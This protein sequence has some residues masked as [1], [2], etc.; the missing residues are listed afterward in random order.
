[1][2][3][4]KTPL[5][6]SLRRVRIRAVL[7]LGT[8]SPTPCS[9]KHFWIFKRLN[10]LT[11]CSISQFLIFRKMF[12]NITKNPHADPKFPRDGDVQKQK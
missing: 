1:M 9:V 2:C 6:V 5:S 8:Q 11:P 10:S 12:E 4:G 3:F 7:V